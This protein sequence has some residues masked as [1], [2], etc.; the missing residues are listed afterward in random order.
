MMLRIWI[1]NCM[2]IT[3]KLTLEYYVYLRVKDYLLFIII[4]STKEYLRE[5]FL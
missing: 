5:R 2:K 3:A 1:L 4:F